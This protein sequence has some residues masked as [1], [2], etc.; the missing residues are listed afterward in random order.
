MLV[1][2]LDSPMSEK[3][4]AGSGEEKT[5]VAKKQGGGMWKILASSSQVQKKSW[6]N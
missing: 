1:P 2:Y 5:S 3:G 6:R 4:K